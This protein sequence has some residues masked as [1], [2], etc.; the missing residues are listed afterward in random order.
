MIA[1]RRWTASG[2]AA[3]EPV[4]GEPGL[5]DAREASR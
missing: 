2:V 1:A 5:A 4:A 3:V